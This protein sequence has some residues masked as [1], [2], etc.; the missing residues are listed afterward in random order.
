MPDESILLNAEQAKCVYKYKNTKIKLYKNNADIWYNKTCTSLLS[1]GILYSRLQRV[2]IPDAVII[3]FVL[4]K[5]GMLMLE[6][7]RGCNV[8][9]I[10]LVNKGIVHRS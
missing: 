7:Y 9:Y 6:T 2:A 3:Q 5:M 10:L 4:L 1:S 8:T